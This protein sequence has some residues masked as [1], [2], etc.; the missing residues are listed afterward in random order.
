[1]GVNQQTQ[2]LVDQCLRDQVVSMVLNIEERLILLSKA[3]GGAAAPAPGVAPL[4]S[5]FRNCATSLYPA[6]ERLDLHVEPHRWLNCGTW[7]RPGGVPGCAHERS[8]LGCGLGLH[9]G[10]DHHLGVGQI[11][12]A[13][14]QILLHVILSPARA[15]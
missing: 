4:S 5:T 9:F 8:G 11:S 1:M 15:G 13:Q 6:I 10:E 14:I 7:P 12:P 3:S 2:S